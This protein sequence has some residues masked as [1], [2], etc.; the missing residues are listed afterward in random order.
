VTAEACP[1]HFVLTDEAV[2]A[3]GTLAKMSPP[4]RSAE[5]VEA[6]RAGLADGTLDAIATDHAPHVAEEKALPFDGAPFGIVGLETALGLTLTHLVAPG[7]LSLSDAIA[8]LTF[9]PARIMGI[10]GGTLQVGDAADVTVIDPDLEWTVD[11]AQFRSKSH[12]T[13][14]AGWRLKGKAVTTLVGGRVTHR[15]GI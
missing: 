12:N 6:V 11:P 13:P 3:H 4:L 5:D 10:R 9:V 7:I 14:F 8:R 1:H 15:E 2:R